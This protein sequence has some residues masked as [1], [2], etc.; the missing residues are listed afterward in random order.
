MATP[1]TRAIFSLNQARELLPQV[2]HLTAD[3]VRRAESLAVQLHGLA[4]DDPEHVSLSAALSGR[5][6]WMGRRGPFPR[7]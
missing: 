5:G 4:D 1:E 7:P 2:K 6:R 3:A